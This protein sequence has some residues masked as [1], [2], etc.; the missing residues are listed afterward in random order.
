[1]KRVPLLAAAALIAL[2]AGAAEAKE[3]LLTAAKPN[4]L[5][6]IDPAARKVERTYDIPGP[7]PSPWTVVPSPDGKIAY[8]LTDQYESISGIDLDSGKEVFRTA[9]KAEGKRT[10]ILPAIDISPDGKELY[11]ILS[12]VKLL[13]SEYQ[14]QDTTLAVFSTEAG[15]T[16]KPV[17]E[18][19]V[20]R[21]IAQLYTAKD[22]K[23]VYGLGWDLYGIDPRT[24]KV[25]VT[26]K[27]TNLK[28][29]NFTP[30]DILAY[31]PQ[32]EQ[33][34]VFS[35]PYFV[36]RTDLPPTDP[37]AFQTGLLTL[38]L[39]NGAVKL[40]EFENTAVPIFSSVVNPANRDEVF[41][42]YS[43][44][45]K[46]NLRDKKLID[47][48]PLAHSYYTINISGDGKEVYTGGTLCDVGIHSTADLKQVGRVEIPGCADMVHGSLRV[49]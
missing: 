21:R 12:P 11:A 3:Y 24:G 1:M 27:L 5:V 28:R 23:T 18:F 8:V 44:L 17:R 31:W 40:R 37:A 45:S 36:G 25:K 30:P 41:T 38:D 15:T 46:V 13:P 43:H 4:K 26:S 19:K 20:P 35:T 47:R 42:V 34:G 14:V 48:V 49:I 6:L 33:T 10:K 7:G 29:T 32:F 9:I 22:G 16:A 39:A 2:A